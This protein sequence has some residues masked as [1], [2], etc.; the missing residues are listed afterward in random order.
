M[1]SG[2]L[3][4][5]EKKKTEAAEAH[6]VRFFLLFLV[7]NILSILRIPCYTIMEQRACPAVNLMLAISINI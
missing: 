3:R 5:K 6:S 2:L 7:H 1:V 4:E